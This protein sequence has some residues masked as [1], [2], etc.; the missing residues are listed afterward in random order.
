VVTVG[1]SLQ[2]LV[3]YSLLVSAVLI[4][5]TRR[6]A[7]FAG[8]ALSILLLCALIEVISLRGRFP[9]N[10]RLALQL[11]LAFLLIPSL[12]VVFVAHSSLIQRRPWSLLL[13][14]PIVFL[15][16]VTVCMVVYNALFATN[17]VR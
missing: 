15:G 4:W 16:T 9:R 1:V 11:W 10:A 12:G 6:D 8:S 13:L 7:G 14:G 3:F 17:R 2:H 5:L